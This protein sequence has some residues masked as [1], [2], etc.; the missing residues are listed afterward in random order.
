MAGGVDDIVDAL[1]ICVFVRWDLGG[2]GMLRCQCGHWAS[3]QEDCR[4]SYNGVD[5]LHVSR[6]GWSSGSC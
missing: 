6:A 2:G 5:L 4:R 1:H 3:Q